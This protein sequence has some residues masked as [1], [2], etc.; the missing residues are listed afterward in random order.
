ML[1]Q[2]DD[3]IRGYANNEQAFLFSCRTLVEASLLELA[4]RVKALKKIY[5]I[6][7]KIWFAIN[8]SLEDPMSQETSDEV[9]TV[10]R[11]YDI[12]KTL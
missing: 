10:W 9:M 12:D 6:D 3:K 2:I 7:Q 8:T 1:T 5:G 11:S 4:N